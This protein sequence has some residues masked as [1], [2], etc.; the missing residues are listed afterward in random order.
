ML[1]QIVLPLSAV[2]LLELVYRKAMLEVSKESVPEMQDD[3]ETVDGLNEFFTTVVWL[4]SVRV[5]LMLLTVT[6]MLMDK[7]S[8]MYLWSMS[9]IVYYLANILESV[10]AQQRLY[11][12]TD[13]VKSTLCYTGF[14]NP[15]EEA[16]VNWFIHTTLFL[17]AVDRDASYFHRKPVLRKFIT[18]AWPILGC[19]FLSL[20][21]F[22]LVTLGA[23]SFNQ[24]IFGASLGFTLAMISHF[25]LKPV[26]LDLQAR[27]T[28]KQM[29]ET[30]LGD[31]VYEDRYMLRVKHLL[32]VLF[33]TLVIPLIVAVIVLKSF[34]D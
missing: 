22:A 6:F 2:F 23:N 13:E 20:M 30:E 11:M 3:F 21:M 9:F 33:L 14:G 28:K 15:S 16:V 5:L 7:A 32:L 4:G 18:Y 27:L 34:G 17:H 10:Y 8:S 26:F 31:E 24:V 29:T 25:W 1:K 19:A 12:I